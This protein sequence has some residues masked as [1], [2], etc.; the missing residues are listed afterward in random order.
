MEVCCKTVSS[1]NDRE[2]TCKITSS[3]TTQTRWQNDNTNGHVNV[4]WENHNQ[5]RSWSKNYKQLR[6]SERDGISFSR[7]RVP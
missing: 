1:G 2:A 3:M 7:G 6:T 4:E 5:P